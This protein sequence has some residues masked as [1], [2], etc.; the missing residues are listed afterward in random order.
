[1]D[2]LC[3]RVLSTTAPK[4]FFL[5]RQNVHQQVISNEKMGIKAKCT[6]LAQA[7]GAGVTL[8]L[9]CGSFLYGHQVWTED[10]TILI[11]CVDS[12]QKCLTTLRGSHLFPGRIGCTLSPHTAHIDVI[13]K[14]EYFP[15]RDE[16]QG[17]FY[18]PYL[19]TQQDINVIILLGTESELRFHCC[20]RYN[21]I[22][23]TNQYS[24][25]S[26]SFTFH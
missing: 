25:L 1:M 18:N 11:V 12:H 9:S 23:L 26:L 19:A 3:S 8:N 15:W 7:I 21:P 10:E 5:R 17:N 16:P 13:E 2:S 24:H 6:N 4:P 20:K 14:Q 22:S